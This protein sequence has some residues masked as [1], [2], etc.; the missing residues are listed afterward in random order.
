MLNVTFSILMSDF[1]TEY[2][3]TYMAIGYVP[4][5]SQLCIT[6]EHYSWIS[7]CM[8]LHEFLLKKNS[9][10]TVEY[11]STFYFHLTKL[12]VQKLSSI[13]LCATFVKRHPIFV[14]FP[15]P[16]IHAFYVF[17]HLCIPGWLYAC[18]CVCL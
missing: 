10:V 8:N 6:A 14:R 12:N 11:C 5:E 17:V 7:Y 18:V 4:I 9:K 15:Y 1:K 13:I 2:N 3:N 16:L